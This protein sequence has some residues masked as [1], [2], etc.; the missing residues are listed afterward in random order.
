MEE[1]S[2]KKLY[3]EKDEADIFREKNLRSIH[4]KEV[5][6][7]ILFWLL[8][9]FAIIVISIVVYICIFDCEQ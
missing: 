5:I 3:P 4:T 7:K 8:L 2:N 9:I 1:N 6:S